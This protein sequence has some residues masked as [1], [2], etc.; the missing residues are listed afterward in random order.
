ME[1]VAWAYF[2]FWVKWTHFQ[3]WIAWT[4]FEKWVAGAFFNTW[5][6]YTILGERITWAVFKEWV[7]RFRWAIKAFART[8]FALARAFIPVT[9][10][11][12]YKR[13]TFPIAGHG[14]L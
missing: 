8:L 10:T 6:A 14:R 11:L 5:V 9:R 1:R 4:L 13:I 2:S 7:A 12:F 3:Q